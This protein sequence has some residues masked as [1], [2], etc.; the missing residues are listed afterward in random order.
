MESLFIYLVKCARAGPKEGLK[1]AK[2]FDD[3]ANTTADL[4]ADI[5][6]SQII[7]TGDDSST[8][9]NTT[10][11]GEISK[12]DKNSHNDSGGPKISA[13]SQLLETL[14]ANKWKPP[15]FECFKEE[16]PC[17]KKLFIAGLP[18]RLQFGLKEKHR[19]YWSVLVILNQQRKQQLNMQLKGHCGT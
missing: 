2:Q 4:L 9:K 18:T 15:L 7:K 17:H 16:G 19:L 14:A 8:I 13:K 3:E 1:P 12:D 11:V 5:N 6:P 10:K